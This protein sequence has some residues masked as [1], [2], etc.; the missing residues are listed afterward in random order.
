[1]I[2]QKKDV[3]NQ[4]AL[5]IPSTPY[6]IILYNYK[7]CIIWWLQFFIFLKRPQVKNENDR[8]K[9][10]NIN[11]DKTVKEEIPKINK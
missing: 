7:D 8:K 1:M 3:A 10:K 9:N 6:Y 5:C 4:N 11:E 2:F